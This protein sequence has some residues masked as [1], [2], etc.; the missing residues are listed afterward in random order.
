M[1][2]ENLKVATTDKLPTTRKPRTSKISDG[3]RVVGKI[4][5]N[6]KTDVALTFSEDLALTARRVITNAQGEL[7]IAGT[8]EVEVKQKHL[9]V[10]ELGFMGR[11][12]LNPVKRA[13][14]AGAVFVTEGD[15]GVTTGYS[16]KD[17]Y[18][19]KTEQLK[20]LM[21]T[22]SPVHVTSQIR[23]VQ[24]AIKNEGTSLLRQE[25]SQIKRTLAP[26]LR[27][28]TDPQSGKPQE[29]EHLLALCQ[30]MLYHE[31]E[32]PTLRRELQAVL[33]EAVLKLDPAM[34]RVFTITE[35]DDDEDI[36]AEDNK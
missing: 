26:L 23:E 22:E 30:F 33:R 19:W 18:E 27:K 5:L 14:M 9:D 20:K 25:E 28:A 15:F 17:P 3:D 29:K 12:E 10:E 36:W 7:E 1:A 16:L 34:G 21:N 24:E 8:P 4:R 13:I 32:R 35:L 31:M 11:G 2:Q 6:E